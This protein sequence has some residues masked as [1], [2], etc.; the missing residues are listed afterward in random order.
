MPTI[1]SDDQQVLK[2]RHVGNDIVHIVW[3]DH[4]RDYRH[5]TM[6]THFNF[7]VIVIY[8]LAQKLFRIQILKKVQVDTGPLQD[9]MV[10]P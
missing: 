10:I 8:P 3:S 5:E 9:G 7:I 2:K 6:L 1:E 4:W